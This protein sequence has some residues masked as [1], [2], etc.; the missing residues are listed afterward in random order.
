MDHATLCSGGIECAHVRT[1]TDGG[2]SLKPGDNWTLP[3]CRV[4]HAEQHQIGESAFERKYKINMKAIAS[5]LW[6]KSPH[7]RKYEESHR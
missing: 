2:A 7:R 6:Q 5:E 1:G 4:H 3:L